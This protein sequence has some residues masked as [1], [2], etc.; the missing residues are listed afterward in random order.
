MIGRRFHLTCSV[1][2][3]WRLLHRHGWSWQASPDAPG[4][5][6]RRQSDCGRRWRCPRSRGSAATGGNLAAALDAWIVFEDEA[7][8][9]MTPPRANTWGPRGQTPVMRVRGRSWRRWSIAALCCHTH[10]T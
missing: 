4:N 10:P 6:T 1:A 7:G 3:A 8:F 2:A 5:A 9:S